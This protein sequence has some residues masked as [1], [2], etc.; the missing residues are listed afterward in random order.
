MVLSDA[1]ALQRL[2]AW[3]PKSLLA[4]P[5]TLPKALAGMCAGK[6]SPFK[7]QRSALVPLAAAAVSIVWGVLVLLRLIL[8]STDCTEPWPILRRSQ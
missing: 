6:Q 4:T 3:E 2:A 8:V 7:P 5:M 1:A